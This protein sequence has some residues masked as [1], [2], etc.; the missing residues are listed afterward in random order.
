MDEE[1][2]RWL[3]EY[4]KDPELVPLMTGLAQGVVN[5]EFVLSEVGLLYLRPDV[6]DPTG[7][8]LLV[9]P[10]G[11]IRREILGDSHL[12]PDQGGRHRGYEEM[13]DELEKVF[14]W[15]GM[16]GD[17]ESHILHCPSCA[18]LQLQQPQDGQN[19]YPNQQVQSERGEVG[20]KSEADSKSTYTGITGWTGDE[21]GRAR[22]ESEAD[23][24][25]EMA[26]A[27]RKA[28]EDAQR[29]WAG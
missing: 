17:I 2:Q 10:K 24:A 1:T 23:M 7:A 5:D 16:E 15:V 22:D 27:M 26:V 28:N 18:Q 25:V 12:N 13:L 21:P 6:S 9:P 20:W 29:P 3:N 11:L 4:P 8:A 19:Q 14:W